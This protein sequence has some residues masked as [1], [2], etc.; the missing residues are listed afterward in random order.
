M[1][2]WRV[3]PG[4]PDTEYLLPRGRFRFRH[5]PCGHEWEPRARIV[6]RCPRCRQVSQGTQDFDFVVIGP[7]P[8]SAVLV[9]LATSRTFTGRK[10]RVEV[11]G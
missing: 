8:R 1:V 4:E 6:R 7:R 2:Q 11:A 3:E 9:R 5:A 10:R